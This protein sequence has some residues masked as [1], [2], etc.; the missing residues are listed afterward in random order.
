MTSKQHHKDPNTEVN[1]GP[2]KQ[3]G[4]PSAPT[5]IYSTWL[6]P[7]P[8]GLTATPARVKPSVEWHG[9]VAMP[10]ERVSTKWHQ[11]WRAEAQMA[12]RT[13]YLHADQFIKGA[14]FSKESYESTEDCACLCERWLLSAMHLRKVP[15]LTS[16]LASFTHIAPA[17][18]V[19]WHLKTGGN[20]HS[21]LPAVFINPLSFSTTAQTLEDFTRTPNLKESATWCKKS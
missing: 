19:L 11:S 20:T 5:A 1:A 17:Q 7:W 2:L 13:D 9:V 16:M 8:Q 3:L 6:P 21:G 14:S 18:S 12:A 15:P 4:Y 10:E